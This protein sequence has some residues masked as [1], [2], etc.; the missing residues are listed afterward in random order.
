MQQKLP[1]RRKQIS[2]VL[3]KKAKR[4]KKG[5][6]SVGKTQTQTQYSLLTSL[7]QFPSLVVVSRSAFSKVSSCDGEKKDPQKLEECHLV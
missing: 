2:H 3:Y 4:E 1:G 5:K 6:V 7:V